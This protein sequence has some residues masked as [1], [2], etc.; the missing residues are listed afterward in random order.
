M[1]HYNGDEYEGE[2]T[3]GMK[4]G[5]GRKSTLENLDEWGVSES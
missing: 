1:K 3:E 2:W 4:S 5:I